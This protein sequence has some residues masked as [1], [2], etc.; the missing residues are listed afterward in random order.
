MTAA[1]PVVVHPKPTPAGTGCVIPGCRDTTSKDNPRPPRRPASGKR[2][3]TI[4]LADLEE[5]L[6]E[7]EDLYATLDQVPTPDEDDP[8]TEVK[9]HSRTGSPA[10]ID[11]H[12]MA[13]RS[14][15]GHDDG[16][17]GQPRGVADVLSDWAD[18]VREERG[19]PPQT[20]REVTAA[21]RTL[22][23]SLDWIAG[24]T[25]VDDFHAD[26]RRIRSS[27]RTAHRLADP[28]PIGQCPEETRPGILCSATL[29]PPP[30]GTYDI[31][32]PSC[33]RTWSKTDLLNLSFQLRAQAA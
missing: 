10:L 19:E 26:I 11:L 21:R 2:I 29:W 23:R 5:W 1:D 7:I 14:H 30:R 13:L 33:R 4:H 32:C 3:C 15:L 17:P 16:N 27:L 22:T 8:Y 24:W 18:W 28:K 25:Y 6:P 12:V 9:R 20:G 31:S